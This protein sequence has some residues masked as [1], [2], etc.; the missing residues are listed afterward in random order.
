MVLLDDEFMEAWKHGIVIL[1]CD[2]IKRRFYPRIFVYSADYPEKWVTWFGHGFLL[3]LYRGI[4][5]LLQAFATLGC[6]HV[7]GA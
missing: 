6:A 2:G 4:G 3:I 5:F 7:P 1:C